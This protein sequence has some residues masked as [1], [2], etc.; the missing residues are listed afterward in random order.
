VRT[1]ELYAALAA[2]RPWPA[3]GVAEARL[4]Y[5]LAL[6]QP[7]G[8]GDEAL[9]RAC[10]ELLGALSGRQEQAALIRRGLAALPLSGELHSLLR[11][12]VLRDEGARALE[13]AYEAP[14]LR[15]AYAQQAAA[16][17]WFHGLATLLAAE[18]DVENRAPDVALAT[19]ARCIE[20]F[21]RAA[22]AAPDFA[23]SAA[24]YQ[25][26]AYAGSAKLLTGAGQLESAVAAMLEAA[27]SAAASFDS[28][29]GLGATPAQTLRALRSALTRS[30]AAE[31]SRAL[32]D[33]LAELGL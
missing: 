16:L 27:R 14:P 13:A 29:D 3:G 10:H 19:Y 6:A 18:R 1:R 17:D 7:A 28:P 22:E 5:E 9:W 33:S 20:R 8:S 11:A 32:D 2:D 15:Q 21:Q 4:A 26:L 31:L 25:C 23:P 12:Q 30:S 24:H